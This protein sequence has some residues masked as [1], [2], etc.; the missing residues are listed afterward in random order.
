MKGTCNPFL[1]Q[2]SSIFIPKMSCKAQGILLFRSRKFHVSYF[3]TIEYTGNFKWFDQFSK[4]FGDPVDQCSFQDSTYK[5]SRRVIHHYLVL[6][7]VKKSTW[8]RRQVARKNK[9]YIS[10]CRPTQPHTYSHRTWFKGWVSY[11]TSTPVFMTWGWDNGE[12]RF[13]WINAYWALARARHSFSHW[14]YSREK[15]N[16]EKSQFLWTL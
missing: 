3:Y 5:N 8:K 13:N 12:I 14:G 2:R 1:L 9:S 6:P 10:V 11:R 7:F 15:K 16:E 4:V